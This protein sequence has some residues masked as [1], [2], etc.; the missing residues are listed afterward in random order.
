MMSK[1][2]RTDLDNLVLDE[3]LHGLR[4]VA[5][6]CQRGPEKLRVQRAA[7]HGQSCKRKACR[8][9]PPSEFVDC[10]RTRRNL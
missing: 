8:E 6:P 2:L 10:L 9:H 4:G 1:A 7:M 5:P 3:G